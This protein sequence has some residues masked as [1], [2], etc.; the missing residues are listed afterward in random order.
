MTCKSL[1]ILFPFY[2]YYC[3]SSSGWSLPHCLL[4]LPYCFVL[5]GLLLWVVSSARIPP[6]CVVLLVS[7]IVLGWLCGA[8]GCPWASWSFCVV[9]LC[10]VAFSTLSLVIL[11]SPV[12]GFDR[13]TPAWVVPLA[14]VGFFFV[15]VLFLLCS[16]VHQF[17]LLL[18]SSPFI[19]QILFRPVLSIGL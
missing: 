7:C 6:C 2:L 13:M 14:G 17:S 9:C 3:Y 8:L 18:I 11:W 10:D 16:S 4:P 15:S 12:M 1:I 19:V 5:W